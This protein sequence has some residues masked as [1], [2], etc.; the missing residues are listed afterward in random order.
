MWHMR[1]GQAGRPIV[2]VTGMGVVTSLGAGKHDNWASA[3]GRPVRHPRASPAS[4]ST[5]CAPPSP[6]RSISCRSTSR[7]R[8]R[9]VASAWPSWR[10]RRRWRRPA[11]A[12]QAIFPARCSSRCRRWSWNGRSATRSPQRPAPTTTVD[13]D[14]LLRAAGQR[15]VQRAVTSASCSAR[16]PSTWRRG[17]AP[18]ARR[19]RISTACASGATAIQLGVEAIRRGEA[20]AALVRRHRC[21]RSTRR[22]LIRF[23][24][25]SALSTR[26]DPPRGGRASRSPRTA[27]AS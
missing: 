8:A 17:S 26:N 10:S 25:L 16:W 6:A 21:A 23:S 7:S 4:R 1:D 5:G 18:R 2:V 13:Y 27:T 12:R 9:A 20:D 19:S 15:Q 14:D 24:L 3:D 11:S 22:A